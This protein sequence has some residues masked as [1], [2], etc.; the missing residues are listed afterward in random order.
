MAKIVPPPEIIL[1]IMDLLEGP[2]DMEALLTAFPRWEQVI[3]ECYWRIRFIKTLILENE[4]LPGPD[5]L[6]WK[7]AYH[8]IDHAFYGIPGLNNQRLIGR[9]LEKT[10]TIFFGHLRMGG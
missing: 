1:I 5:N 6:D 2:R 7:H 9:R 4:E 10:R 3:P 8:K